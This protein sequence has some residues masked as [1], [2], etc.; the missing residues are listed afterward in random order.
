[1]AMYAC[2]MKQFLERYFPENVPKLVFDAK[3][4]AYTYP[5]R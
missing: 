4:G 2:P 5:E 3:R 1:V